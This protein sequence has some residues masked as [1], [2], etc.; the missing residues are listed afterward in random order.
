MAVDW[1]PVLGQG[2]RTELPTYPF[3]R[4]RYWMS[5][6]GGTVDV[7]GLG[8][9]PTDHA[10]LG[11]SLDLPDSGGTVLT[12]RLSRAAHGWLA[13]HPAVPSAAFVDLV[14]RAGD[15]AGYDALVSLETDA[16]LVVPPGADVHLRVV[17]SP[18]GE[19]GTGSATVHARP[20]GAADWNCHATA[21]L[22]ARGAA[23][24]ADPAPH[25]RRDGT[26]LPVPPDGVLRVLRRDGDTARAHLVLPAGHAR[27]AARHGVHPALLDGAWAAARHSG[28]VGTDTVAADWSDLR[29]HASGATEAW[30]E[31]R[32]D[33]TGT[34]HV[35]LT[36]THGAPLLTG[37]VS[38]V[39]EAATARLAE[40]ALRD[41]PLY[42][43]EWTSA[44]PVGDNHEGPEWSVLETGAEAH[45]LA[46]VP[47]GPRVVLWPAPSD[48][49]EAP[50]AVRD[51]AH[52]TLA[53]LRAFL[54]DDRLTE[55][56]L[57]VVTRQGAAVDSGAEPATG[58]AA[59]VWGLVRSAQSE[60]PG[61]VLLV[62]VP[63]GTP[64]GALPELAARAVAAGEPQAAVRDGA[65][66]L[67]RLTTVAAPALAPLPT[68]PWRLRDDGRGRVDGVSPQPVD[69]DET[70]GGPLPAGAVRVSVRAAGVNFRDVLTVL[71]MYPGEPLPLGME[72][73]G[74]VTE[75]GPEVTGLAVGDRVMGLC[76]GSF[77][78][79]VT[80]DHRMWSR[81]P[82]QWSFAD[83]A[84]VPVTFLT[85][86]YGLFDLGGLQAGERVLVHSAAGGVGMAAVQLAR[87]AGAE[88]FATAS[89]AKQRVLPLDGEHVA[90]SRDLEF[91]ERFGEVDVVL[92]SLAGE[93]IDTSLRL[94]GESGRFVEMGKTDLRDPADMPP[95]VDYRS[96]DL[97][98]AGPQRMGAMFAELR[99][100]FEEGVLEPLPLACWD[101]R[102]AA[103]AMRFMSQARHVG[104]VVLTVPRG[105]DRAGTVLV[106]GGTGGVGAAVA[107]RLVESHGVRRL[108]L[109]S[110]RG[111]E[112]P[113]AVELRERLAESG[114]EVVVEACDV[115]DREQVRALLEAIPASAPL[116][117]VVHAAGVLDDGVLTD[118]TPERIDGVLAPKADAARHLHDLT[119]HLDLAAFVLFSSAAG[120]LGSPGQGNYAAANGVLDALAADRA[121]DGLPATSM[122]WGL[123][124]GTGMGGDLSEQDLLRLSRG[125][126]T[127]LTPERGLALFDTALRSAVPA[128]VPLALDTARLEAAGGALPALLRGLVRRTVRRQADTGG[129]AAGGAWLEEVRAVPPA[130]RQR[131]V[132]D[133]VTS[134]LA[135]VLGHADARRIRPQQ[136]FTELGLDSLTGVELRNQLAA[137]SGLRLPATLVFDHPTP[138]AIA[139][140]LA[141][142]LFGEQAADGAV[143]GAAP[144][145]PAAPVRESIARLEEHLTKADAADDAFS[146]VEPELRR[147]LSLWAAARSGGD[148]SH[149]DVADANAE[150]LFALLDN[151]LGS[152]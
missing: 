115:S 2:R 96:F 55:A 116:T 33:D 82:D 26:D 22:T 130:E 139:T 110:R 24:P 64:E 52:A 138:Q 48:G 98:E 123:W 120:V 18:P 141:T 10:V 131:K 147:L 149:D 65:V 13:E 60:H 56:R 51:A 69:P 66:R 3:Q 44:A 39:G 43:V 30:A 45:A 76:T 105:L 68:T 70:G 92:N 67:P 37:V 89:P 136:P 15:E 8:L 9:G 40:A 127:P 126:L 25:P 72:A 152:A 111:I 63:P 46:T 57:A 93:F 61:R 81:F 54:T 50:T 90:S 101:V 35:T 12:G 128:V 7:R 118:L 75:T 19:D 137:A 109:T 133:L 84:T 113:G 134:L 140:L 21:V 135:R 88:V 29:L 20:E 85:A 47:P 99:K 119:R 74:V 103:E 11:A 27:D 122:A 143:E 59:A 142:E 151:E 78:P 49:P 114:A 41:D 28:L 86:W 129:D 79:E 144:R 102:R 100:L 150:T 32:H 14:V 6:G 91:G 148:A 62:D 108:V 87:H 58:S 104:K 1:S 112:A 125:G 77:G 145:D 5:G 132:L 146:E 94:L 95:G 124:A 17:V 80:G 107:S 97:V 36:D 71:G 16:P 38:R 31:L 53:V 73:A 121:R 106:T 4:D 83:A 42:T 117:G 34:L 23:D